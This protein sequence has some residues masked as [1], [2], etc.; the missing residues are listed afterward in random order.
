MHPSLILADISGGHAPKFSFDKHFRR[1]Y[2]QVY[3]FQEYNEDLHLSLILADI[4]GV[5]A[6]KGQTFQF[7]F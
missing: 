7:K 2:K 3:F 4:S 1:T 5:H 6:P